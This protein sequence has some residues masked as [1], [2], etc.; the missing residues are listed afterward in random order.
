MLGREEFVSRKI[1]D[2]FRRIY[3]NGEQSNESLKKSLKSKCSQEKGFF[4]VKYDKEYHAFVP[5]EVI[6]WIIKYLRCRR[7]KRPE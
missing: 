6:K 2:S 4:S 3:C 1:N 7:A 5:M